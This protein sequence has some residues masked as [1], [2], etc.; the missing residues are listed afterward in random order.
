MKQ[1]TIFVGSARKKHT[2]QSARLF[3]EHLEASGEVRVEVVYL[4]DYNLKPCI[5]CFRCFEKGEQYSPLSDDRDHLLEKIRVSDGIVLSSPNYAFQVSGLL[6]VFLDRFGFIFHRP[7][8][9]GK[10]YTTI[11]TQGIFGGSSIVKYLDFVGRGLGCETIPGICLST[12]EP[13]PNR[14]HTKNSRNIE[15]L[16]SRFCEKLLSKHR[17]SP[18]L[19]SL[20]MFRVSRTSMHRLLDGSSCD[21]RYFSSNNWFSSDYYYPVRLGFFKK[22]VG[23]LVDAWANLKYDHAASVESSRA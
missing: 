5:G 22:A 18:A 19:F 3:A 6:K 11:V 13:L 2:Y 20:V 14:V 16:A 10:A 8:Y 12:M 7:R 9:F 1:V 23:R 4:H 21:F 17:P 15:H